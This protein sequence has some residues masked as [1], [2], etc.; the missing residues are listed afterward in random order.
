[1]ELGASSYTRRGR[2]FLLV[3]LATFLIVTTSMGGRAAAPQPVDAV[4]PGQ[5]TPTEVPPS[6]PPARA[7][8]SPAG[9][10]SGGQTQ[11]SEAAKSN[12]DPAGM[13]QLGPGDLVEI[14]VYNVPELNTKAR[15]S[16]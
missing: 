4:Q 5:I 11:T 15:V 14:N 13:A 3:A 12:G 7:T 1:M 2:V 16:N 10:T 6:Q 8:V 9:A